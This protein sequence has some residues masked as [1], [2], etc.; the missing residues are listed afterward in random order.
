MVVSLVLLEV[1]SLFGSK[2]AYR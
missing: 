1:M 2:S